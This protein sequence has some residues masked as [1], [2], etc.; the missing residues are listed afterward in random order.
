[1]YGCRREKVQTVPARMGFEIGSGTAYL[2]EMQITVLEPG[3][4]DQELMA[5]PKD[6]AKREEWRKRISD[7]VKKQWEDPEYR[8]K[9]SDAHKGKPSARLGIPHTDAAKLKMS[10]ANRGN[11][12]HLGKHHS[13]ETRKKLS[14]STKRQMENPESRRVC[15]EAAKGNKNCTGR[16][17]SE[18]TRKKLRV[19]H[20]GKNTGIKNPNWKGGVSY[21][22][23]CPKFNNEF[24]ER[25][26]AFFGYQ[27]MMPGCNRVW[28]QGETRLAVHHVNFKKD[29]CCSEDIIPLFVPVCHGS[30]HTKTNHNRDDWERYF[31]EIINRDYGGKCYFTKEEMNEIRRS[32]N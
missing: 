2:P 16:H 1:M 13:D 32:Q 11:T 25:V 26:R 14:E 21:G 3:T 5:A 29:S 12:F 28:Q 9:C 4:E 8:K 10:I 19:S 7:T 27:C 23:Y 18:D 31:T 30:C 15:S 6:P 20:L 22:P 17:A 24:K